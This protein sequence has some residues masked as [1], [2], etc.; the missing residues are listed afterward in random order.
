MDQPVYAEEVE[1][2]E[3]R[4]KQ[5][6][7]SE[8]EGMLG[9]GEPGRVAIGESEEHPDLVGRPDRHAGS[10]PPDDPLDILAAEQK[11]GV[12]LVIGKFGVVFEPVSLS[13]RYVERVFERAVE[14]EN[15]HA[16]DDEEPENQP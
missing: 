16:V 15:R 4:H 5:R 13:S 3:D 10:K 9:E 14:Q 6:E 1:L 12:L 7:A 11:G 8:I 2:V